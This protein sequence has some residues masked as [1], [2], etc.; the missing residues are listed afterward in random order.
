MAGNR[1]QRQGG[2]RRKS[3]KEVT[4]ASRGCLHR[5]RCRLDI[6]PR[7]ICNLS[8]DADIIAVSGV[9]VI[10][11]VVIY[12]EPLI[13]CHSVWSG[14]ETRTKA[15][16]ALNEQRAARRASAASHPGV[17]LQWVMDSRFRGNDKLLF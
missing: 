11:V 17:S 1:Y 5:C 3:S 16:S 10:Y 12:K 4:A 2:S 13:N 7:Y 9:V 14:A 6:R 8:V 15:H